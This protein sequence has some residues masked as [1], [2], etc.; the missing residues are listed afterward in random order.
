VSFQRGNLLA[1]R[2]L[3]NVQD[4]RGAREA[5][6]VDDLDERSE[7]TCIQFS[8]LVGCRPILSWPNGA[9]VAALNQALSSL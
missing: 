7:T 9:Q 4:R 1:E 2:R 3:R 8:T 5:A 6:D